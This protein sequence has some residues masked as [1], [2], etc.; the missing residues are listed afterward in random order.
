MNKDQSNNESLRRLYM[1][2]FNDG[3]WDIVLGLWIVVGGIMMLA[4]MVYL[5]AVWVIL[6]API[7]WAGKRWITMPRLTGDELNKVRPHQVNKQRGVLLVGG[8]VLLV[9]GTFVLSTFFVDTA[10]AVPMRTI[11]LL[12]ALGTL[13]AIL[14]WFGVRFN[15]PRWYGYAGLLLVSALVFTMLGWANLPGMMIGIG[16]VI[17]LG[18]SVVLI[19]F[20]NSHPVLP[21]S[22]RPAW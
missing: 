15:A 7:V 13:V 4:D 12:I 5:T 18:G 21:D 6:L 17:A 1:A 3:I 16:S 19:R 9:A 11:W 2:Y 14:I 8:L 22:D 10:W 20:L